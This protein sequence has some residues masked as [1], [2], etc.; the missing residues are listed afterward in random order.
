M[1]TLNEMLLEI[2][3][4]NT[5]KRNSIVRNVNEMLVEVLHNQNKKLSRL[6]LINECSM[7]RYQDQ[8]G[9]ELKVEMLKDAKVVEDFI[10]ITKT[11]RNGIDTSISRS[12]NNSSFH[13][14]PKYSNLEL[15]Q[16]ASGK[17]T[18][19]TRK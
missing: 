2:T 4:K 19:T 10:K 6:E 1:K 3:V 5:V 12:N 8:N 11:I 18:I 15:K 9:I 13:Y 7:L 14:N 16:D 17:F